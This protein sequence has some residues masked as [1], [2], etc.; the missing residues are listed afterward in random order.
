M[1]LAEWA[2]TTARELLKDPLP[3][4]WAHTQGVAA[5]ARA[6]TLVLGADAEVVEAAAWLHDIGYAPDLHHTGF[7]PLDGAWH[8]RHVAGAEP[9]LCR[10]VAHHSCALIEAE[11]RGL[12]ADLV[13]EF[14]PPPR[15]LAEALIYCDMTTGPDGQHLDVCDRLAE[16]RQRYGPGDAVTRAITRSA[17]TLEAAV[18]RVE[19]RLAAPQTRRMTVRSRRGQDGLAD[20]R[21]AATFQEVVDPYT[22]RSVHSI[23]AE[24]PDAYPSHIGCLA[25]GSRVAADWLSCQ[26]DREFLTDLAVA[27]VENYVPGIAVD[28]DDARDL[29]V[30]AALLAGLADSGLRH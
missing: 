10:M 22:H 21:T 28:A 29:A 18:R 14:R 27:R 7:H 16:I 19:H 17:P 6:L 11:E 25:A 30:D 2:E 1:Q 12:A 13:R 5:K 8:L 20:V 15:D 24:F 23:V 9:V 3:R 4:R 26:E